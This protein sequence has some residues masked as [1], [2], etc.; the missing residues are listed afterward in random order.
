MKRI[1]SIALAAALALS[2]AACGSAVPEQTATPDG[3]LPEVHAQSVT[4]PDY[5][6]L[7]V[8]AQDVTALAAQQY[9]TARFYLDALLEMELNAGT[10]AEYSSLLDEAIAQFSLADEYAEQALLAA[11]LAQMYLESEL[12]ASGVAYAADETGGIVLLG[13]KAASGSVSGTPQIQ[14]LAAEDGDALREW[15]ED[16]T[17]KFDAVQ[18]NQK[19]KALGE[20]LGVDA[21]EAYNQLLAAQAI[22][23]QG[24][25]ADAAFYDTAM[26]AAMVVKTTCKIT[27]I[28]GTAIATGGASTLLEGAA[29]VVSGSSAIIEVAATTSTIILGES[30]GLT[31]AYNKVQDAMAPVEAVLGLLTLDF[32]SAAKLSTKTNEAGAALVGAIDYVG[33]GL[34]NFFQ[35]GKIMGLQKKDLAQGS[36][37]LTA[38]TVDVAAL[39][40]DAGTDTE[41]TGKISDAFKSAGMEGVADVIDAAA[42]GMSAAAGA[43]TEPVPPLEAAKTFVPQVP[44]EEVKKAVQQVI[45]N[46][47]LDLGN[48]DLGLKNSDLAGL[49]SI[50]GI[51]VGEKYK[52]TMT[53]TPEGAGG[54]VSFGHTARYEFSEGTIT[55]TIDEPP[56]K[57]GTVYHAGIRGTFTFTFTKAEDGTITGSGKFDGEAYGSN[58]AT[59]PGSIDGYTLIKIG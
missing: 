31:L 21:R 3:G 33:N 34:R 57:E 55:F 43:A 7:Y 17:A 41:K 11:D 26:K 58:F 38:G 36:K 4:V 39:A 30:S 56:S 48:F 10:E 29:L 15:A 49:Y 24:A 59:V 20:Q 5:P 18:G 6:L 25:D 16:I 28:A 40:S 2:M 27:V 46:S 42:I 45:K 54:T 22:I 50:T 52:N 23:K 14:L 47:G 32:S 51:P 9:I 12:S 44:I 19:C 53:I 1:I 13:Y 8:V 35:D 37:M